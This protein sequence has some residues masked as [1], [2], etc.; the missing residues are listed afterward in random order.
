MGSQPR[1]GVVSAEEAVRASVGFDQ[2][3]VV[4]DAV[5]WL[6]SRPESEVTALVRWTVGSGSARISPARFDVGSTVH[7]YGGGSYAVAGDQ[8][9]CVGSEGLYRLRNSQCELVVPGGAFGDLVAGEDELF[10]VRE[11]AQG[12][13]LVAVPL[14]GAG[15]VRVLAETSGFFGAPRPGRSMLAWTCWTTRDMPWDACEL[16][17]APY[18]TGGLIGDPVRV[19]GGPQ[20]S[21]VEPRWGPDGA[22]YF[23]SDRSGWWNLYRW[24]GGPVEPVAP[25]ARDCAAEPWELGYASY[26]FLPDGRVVIAAQQGPRHRLA[27]VEPDGGA[28]RQVPLPY[29]SI[30]PYLAASG[31]KVA[32]VGASATAAPQVALVDLAGGEVEVLARAEGSD[33]DA[34]TLS[35][36]MEVRVP[37]GGSREVVALVYPPTGAGADWRAP[38]IVRAHPGPTASALLRL[39]WQTQFFTSR[40][41]AVVDVD[42][43]GS[44]GYGRAFRQALYGRWGIDD[45]VD[46]RSVADHL[47]AAA[48]AIPGQIFIR[49]ASAGGHT[50]L[51]AVATDGPF[52]AATAVSAIVDPDRW[53]AAVPRF[54][55]AHAARLRGGAGPVRAGDIRR[56]VLLIHGTADEI[57]ADNDIRELAAELAD[58]GAPHEL[59]LL[60]GVG[61]YVASSSQAA[62]AL[63]SELAF[64]RA[65]INAVVAG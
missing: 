14:D 47:L 53:A 3:R 17:A 55:R 40:G 52:A 45:V 7:A 25:M 24:H 51:H 19:A 35:V 6:E 32:L 23:V 2:L 15:D 26:D 60:N 41:F 46:C 63:E 43:T 8:V 20:E 12:D 5:Y 22:L 37:T 39:D 18:Q 1:D 44:T 57:V 50:A 49:G 11:S 38:V 36:A 31:S 61:H 27:V 62:R 42:Y 9:W 34:A 48:H 16:W 56:P 13:A 65:M 21:A 58:R 10:G 30:K 33:F 59:L 64:Y 54:Q 28:V 29:T 4:A